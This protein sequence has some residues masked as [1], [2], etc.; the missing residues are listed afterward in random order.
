MHQTPFN[1]KSKILKW[2]QHV[3]HEIS[4]LDGY[5]LFSC[6]IMINL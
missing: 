3:I 1:L 6:Y 4:A 2:S 5:V